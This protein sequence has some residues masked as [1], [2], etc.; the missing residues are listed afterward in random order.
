MI[1]VTKPFLPPIDKYQDYIK[2][3]WDRAWLTNHGPVVNELEARLK[4]HLDLD[5][6]L[7][8]SN[9]T[10]AI[11]IAIKALKLKGEIITTPFSYV[12]TTSSIIW[13]NCVPVFSDISSDDCNISVE[14]I[15]PLI[16][17]QT[18]AI[19]ATHVYGNP[20]EI[21]KIESIAKRYDL[22]VIYD[23]AHCFDTL[24]KGSSVLQYGDISTISF[25]A[26][27]LFH[28][29][30]GGAVVS[31]N[32]DLHLKM[33]KLRNF[34][35]DGPNDFYSIGINGKNSEF[36][37]A[38]GLVNLDYIDEI[39]EKRKHQYLLYENRLSESP[40]RFIKLNKKATFNYAYCPIILES[41][42]SLLKVIKILNDNYINPR[43]YFY[44]SLNKLK[45]LNKK[46]E[47]PISESIS[48]RVLSLPLYH[49]LSD[50]TI[51]LICRLINQILNE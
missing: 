42:V 15:E 30:E 38:M 48:P 37:A 1:N 18:S 34:G 5:N 11:Q 45:Y 41:E 36:H 50:T 23:A 16:T 17:D 43:R 12:A 28:T 6:L 31:K 40:L 51:D 44:P 33:S 32:C 4:K 39:K 13:E 21:D 24:Y 25:H 14:C 46:F 26:T 19:L 49:D 29:I 22:K 7:Y 9:G 8:L 2:K 35:H 3:I 27:K 20:C 10:I 47:C